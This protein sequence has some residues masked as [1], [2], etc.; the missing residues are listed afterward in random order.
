MENEKDGYSRKCSRREENVRVQEQRKMGRGNKIRERRWF[1]SHFTS[2]VGPLNCIKL[3][4][5]LTC[6]LEYTN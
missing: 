4:R 5:Q 2:V 1:D 3:N 6:L